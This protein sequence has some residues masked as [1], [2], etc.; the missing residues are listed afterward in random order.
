[1]NMFLCAWSGKGRPILIYDGFFLG[2]FCVFV[3]DVKLNLYTIYFKHL[4]F[5]FWSGQDDDVYATDVSCEKLLRILNR[6]R[7]NFFGD[8]VESSSLSWKLSESEH[9]LSLDGWQQHVIQS[10][11]SLSQLFFDSRQGRATVQ[12]PNPILPSPMF[13][14]SCRLFNNRI[15]AQHNKMEWLNNFILK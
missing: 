8:G 5:S 11:I 4:Q 7:T 6:W 2:F 15:S 3:N 1:M 14:F 10:T 9:A 12:M 13:T